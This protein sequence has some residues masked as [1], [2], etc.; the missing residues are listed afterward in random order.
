MG[1]AFGERKTAKDIIRE[2]RRTLNRSI[3][4]QD[5]DRIS[6]E[7]DEK[8]LIL[9]IKKAAQANQLKSMR[10][11]AKDLVRIRRHQAKSANMTAQLRAVGFQMTSVQS[12]QQLAESVS[13]VT[14]S[15]TTLNRQMSVPAMR[16]TMTEFARQS[17]KMEQTQNTISDAI[18]DTMNGEEDEAESDEVVNQILDE[19]GIKIKA[20]LSDT[21]D[22]K[23]AEPESTPVENEHYE[24]LQA[25]LSSLKSPQ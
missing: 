14:R 18:D 6:L 15:M 20:D 22:K 2:N 21:P 4:Q 13:N 9:N 11:M 16:N 8:T 7:N 23:V 17:D 5:R 25:R 12:T 19:I 24:I 1:N 10:I 3:R